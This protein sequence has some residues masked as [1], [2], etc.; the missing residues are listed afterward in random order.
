MHNRLTLCDFLETLLCCWRRVSD[1]CSQRHQTAEENSR[2][3]PSVQPIS[4]RRVFRAISPR[5]ME[6]MMLEN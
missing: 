6:E 3:V 1:Y 5:E 2:H 4:M